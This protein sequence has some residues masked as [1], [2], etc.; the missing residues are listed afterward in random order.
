M[1]SLRNAV[2][3]VTHKE[4]SQPT[5]RAHLGILEKK[6]DYKIRSN[7][8]H[9]KQDMITNLRRK[10]AMKNPDEFYFGMNSS[11]IHEGRHRKLE[12]AKQK[13]K[14]AEIGK[15]AIKI[16]I[17]QDLSYI[18]MQAMKD[19]RK[20]ERMRSS[21]QY[22]GDNPTTMSSEDVIDKKRRHTVFVDTREKADN[23]D[24]AEHFSTVP[25]LAGRSFNR[26]RKETLLKMGSNDD[27]YYDDHDDV[28]KMLSEEQMK[29]EKALA[30]KRA[31]SLAKARSSAYS[32]IE[33]RTKRLDALKNA[34][35][36]LVT[37]KIVASK[38]RKRKIKDGENGKPSVYVFRRKR[39]K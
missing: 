28:N 17:T 20:I 30:K 25:E 29:K 16:M 2:K 12:E 24:V 26:P 33:A 37:E 32:E 35:A 38:G 15:D 19:L 21:L 7:D 39:A 4:R 18:R 10:A 3:R 8:Y 14:A 6:K 5:H 27:G 1:S 11:G 9:K 23:F 31:I 34:E 22:L 13:E 36:H